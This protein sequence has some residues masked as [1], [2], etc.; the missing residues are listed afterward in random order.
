MLRHLINRLLHA[1]SGRSHY[2]GYPKH[3]K[4]YKHYSSSAHKYYGHP[5]PPHY[6]H[7]QCGSPYYKKKYSSFS[8]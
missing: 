1:V 6:G 8:S 4:P 2:K 3:Y 7:N 5:R